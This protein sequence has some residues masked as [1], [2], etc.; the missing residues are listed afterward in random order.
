MDDATSTELDALLDEDDIHVYV[1]YEAPV[2][3]L[4]DVREEEV[5]RVRID[6][7]RAR[8]PEH[9]SVIF[10]VPPALEA[11]RTREALEREIEEIAFRGKPGE[12]HSG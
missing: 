3:V 8:Q 2:E 10:Q 6:L 5:L 12:N 7:S 1:S 11:S 9:Q 4:V